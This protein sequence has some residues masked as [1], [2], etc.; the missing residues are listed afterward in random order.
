MGVAKGDGFI[1]TPLDTCTASGGVVRG[2]S[3]GILAYGTGEGADEF[4]VFVV[5]GNLDFEK[6]F[7]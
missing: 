3:L 4:E 5:T 6:G 2:D 1:V 7:H